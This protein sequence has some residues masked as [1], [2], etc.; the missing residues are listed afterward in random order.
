MKKPEQSIPLTD[1]LRIHEK[2]H[3]HGKEPPASEKPPEESQ[4]TAPRKITPIAKPRKEAT[5]AIVPLLN[6]KTEVERLIDSFLMN[7]RI[8]GLSTAE[9]T[10]ESYACT[11]RDFLDY[12]K[13]VPLTAIRAVDIREYLAWLLAQGNSA[14]S[15]N[16]KTFALRAFFNELEGIGAIPVSPARLIKSRKF[17]KRLVKFLSREQTERLIAACRTPLELAVLE[18]L[19]ASGMR[20]SELRSLRIENIDWKTRCARIIGKGDRERLV[21]LNRRAVE[22][23]RDIIGIREKG[24]VFQ[25]TRRAHGSGCIQAIQGYWRFCYAQKV[26]LDGEEVPVPKIKCLGSVA[27]LTREEATALAEKF[28]SELL[29]RQLPPQQAYVPLMPLARRALWSIVRRVGLRAGLQIHPH[30]M[31]HSFATHLLD[32]GADIFSVKELLGHESIQSTQIYTHVTPGKM[33]ETWHKFHPHG[34]SQ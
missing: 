17:P 23:M 27:K 11:I 12:V 8:R 15:V 5:S 19:Y 32:G 33:L 31:R 7:R 9:K 2:F 3:P 29:G 20:I 25:R 26:V 13:D 28:A 4:A 18:T 1:L 30:L 34:D 21:P 6:P 16:Q 22:A 24:F 14:S 10:R